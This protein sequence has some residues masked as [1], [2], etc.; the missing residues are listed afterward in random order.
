MA[1]SLTRA[2]IAGLIVAG[3]LA[4]AELV[5]VVILKLREPGMGDFFSGSFGLY[6]SFASM[7]S[8]LSMGN[9]LASAAIGLAA[10]RGSNSM[11]TAAAAGAIAGAAG[12][13]GMVL[14]SFLSITVFFD[15]GSAIW[16]SYGDTF[17]N[18]PVAAVAACLAAVGMA[19]ARSP[20]APAPAPAFASYGQPAASTAAP[21][22]TTGPVSSRRVKCPRCANIITV[23]PGQRPSCDKCGLTS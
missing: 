22:I 3:A 2:T 1:S 19:Y 10:G 6:A 12:Y 14:V 11:G 4:A 20:S 16:D 17:W 9:P 21:A 7:F 13:I 23:A 8:I 5:A 15:G 18:L